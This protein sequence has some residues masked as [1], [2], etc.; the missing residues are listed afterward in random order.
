MCHFLN[1]PYCLNSVSKVRCSL[2]DNQM[3]VFGNFPFPPVYGQLGSAITKMCI[4][5]LLWSVYPPT[6]ENITE[7]GGHTLHI[8]Q[9][10]QSKKVV[11]W[12]LICS[13][14][15]LWA[16]GSDK[17][18]TS[19]ELRSICLAQLDSSDYL[20]TRSTWLQGSAAEGHT[21]IFFIIV[22][23]HYSTLG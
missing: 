3:D 14:A 10:D 11:I 4:Y 21:A 17:R 9:K 12:S 2:C 18:N 16:G 5:R 1:P 20:P 13:Q 8:N 7:T 22:M 23:V 6:G 19:S 15:Q